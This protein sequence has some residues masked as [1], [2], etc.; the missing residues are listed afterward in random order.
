[1]KKK[2][3]VAVNIIVLIFGL[4]F[5][6]GNSS[7]FFNKINPMYPIINHFADFAVEMGPDSDS[8]LY[9]FAAHGKAMVDNYNDAFAYYEK[10]IELAPESSNAYWIRGNTKYHLKDYDGA[11][12]DYKKCIELKCRLDK[13]IFIIYYIAAFRNFKEANGAYELYKAELN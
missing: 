9:V 12:E 6:F 13:N 1:M 8:D 4:M 11:R 5:I 7:S 2:I 10:A 3:V